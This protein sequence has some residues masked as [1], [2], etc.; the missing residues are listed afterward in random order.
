MHTEPAVVAILCRV[1]VEIIVEE[2]R[3]LWQYGRH[4]VSCDTVL[5]KFIHEFL[6]KNIYSV[7]QVEI[8]HQYSVRGNNLQQELNIT[9]LVHTVD[10]TES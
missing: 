4:H 1:M 10:K 6:P 9:L 5:I 8:E 3:L 7:L 2:S